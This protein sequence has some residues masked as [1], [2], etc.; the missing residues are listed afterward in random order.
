MVV[1]ALSTS[2]ASWRIAR[3]VA[4]T[5]FAPS[6]DWVSAPRAASAAFCAL[7]ATSCTAL[8]ISVAAVLT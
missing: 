1:E 4:P 8:L 3:M 6:R 7:R 5:T 2:W